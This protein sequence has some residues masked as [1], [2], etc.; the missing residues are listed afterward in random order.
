MRRTTLLLAVLLLLAGAAR[1]EAAER[2][3][4]QGWLGVTADKSFDL[5]DASEWDRMV[6][7]GAE[8]VRTAFYWAPLQPYR[9]AAEVPA[10][11]ASRFRDVDG[12]PTDFSS[13]D[14]LAITAAQR[15]LA[16]LPVVQWTPP[17]AELKPGT[18]RSP[19]GDPRD[20]RRIFT[21]LVERYGPKGSLW[22]ERPDVPRRPVRAWQ[23]F[24]EP[25][26]RGFWPIRPFAPSYI[27]TLRAA[28]KG[29]HGADP[30]ATVVL[31][32]LTGSSWNALESLYAAGARGS[33]D[34]VAIHPYTARPADVLRIVRYA[35]GVM[36]RHHDGRRPIWITEFSWAAAAGKV[37]DPPSWAAVTERVQARRLDRLMR[38]MVAARKRLRI[39]R[40]FW[41]TWL[42]IEAG[43]SAFDW[44]GLRRV[45]DG[46]RVD[47]RVL[48]VF[49]RW[50]RRLEGCEKAPGDARR[51]A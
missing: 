3:V 30:G 16:L 23:V 7:A 35:R 13:T 47:A 44:S 10:E 27:A 39:A 19:P 36:R 17:W 38:R 40:V 42:S 11:A 31:A 48:T 49:R 25:N 26:L 28:E 8:S 51:C 32:G 22:A 20:V 6:A 37:A 1:T 18:F 5:G 21:A 41:Y 33:F 15:G 12:V 2:H 50:A 46:G 45:R 29:I 24:N 43:P 9:T 14:A 34:A 4:P